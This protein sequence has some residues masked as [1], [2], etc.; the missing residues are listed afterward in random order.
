MGDTGMGRRPGRIRR[1]A[2]LLLTGVC[3][4]GAVP[5]LADQAVT[6][7]GGDTKD[8]AF[9]PSTITINPGEK[10]TFQNVDGGTHNVAW[11][12]NGVPASPSRAAPIWLSNPSRT[13]TTPGTYRFRCEQHSG[14]FSPGSGMV[15]Q[16]VVNEP[17][18]GSPPPPPPPPPDTFPPLISMFKASAGKKRVTLSFSS[19]EAG[20]ASGTIDRKNS[21][22]KFKRFGSV[23]FNVV[24]ANNTVTIKK[25]SS[26]TKLT[27]GKFRITFRVKDAAGN[28][29]SQKTATFTIK[30]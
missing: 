9:Y 4:F 13:F 23:S 11:E 20:K 17:G 2:V 21:R 24:D 22:G 7:Q 15:G 10:V 19:S 18:G 6:T 29:S 26:G 1:L 5:A 28:P 30:H 25:T 14:S 12:D 3:F 27:T 16:V 8:A